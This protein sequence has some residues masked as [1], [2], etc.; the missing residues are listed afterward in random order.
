MKRNKI[1]FTARLDPLILELINTMTELTYH[2]K[3][4]V[5]E[6]AVFEY[7]KNNMPR[8]VLEMIIERNTKV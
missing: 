5:I 7:A 4:G 2:N 8:E 1:P 3:T 6:N